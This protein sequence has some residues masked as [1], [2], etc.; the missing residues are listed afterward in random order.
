M[1]ESKVRHLSQRMSVSTLAKISKSQEDEST[2]GTEEIS[3]AKK[4]NIKDSIKKF[5]KILTFSIVAV[6]AIGCTT[7]Q[8]K[9]MGNTE[10]TIRK[11]AGIY[12]VL[13][14]ASK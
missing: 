4:I 13:E 6:N 5:I 9:G 12:K 3:L 7:E 1:E 8:A 11:A 10:Y 2:V 14:R